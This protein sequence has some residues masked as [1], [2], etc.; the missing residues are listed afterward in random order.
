MKQ[1]LQEKEKRENRKELSRD[2]K[3]K[4][5]EEIHL[6]DHDDLEDGHVEQL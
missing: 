4:K 6:N 2:Q 3:I 1:R 5:E